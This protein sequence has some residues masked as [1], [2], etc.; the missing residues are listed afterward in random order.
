MPTASGEAL[1]LDELTQRTPP[2]L[3]AATEVQ[4]LNAIIHN[5]PHILFLRLLARQLFH[6]YPRGKGHR[7][8]CRVSLRLLSTLHSGIRE[9][10]RVVVQAERG[11][12]A[13]HVVVVAKVGVDFAVEGKCRW[14]RVQSAVDVADELDWFLSQSREQF[15]DVAD[16]LCGS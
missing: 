6:I 8:R 4:R 12:N 10:L 16:A 11:K 15:A 3:I 9:R 14:I 7:P 2:V 13:S 5:N 1:A